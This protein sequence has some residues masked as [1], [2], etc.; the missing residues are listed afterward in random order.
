MNSLLID[1]VVRQTT[2]LIATLATATGNR[3]SL[4]HVANEVFANLSRELKAQG[5]GNKVIADMFGMAL[6]T[7]HDRV[8]RLSE[9]HSQQGASLWDAVL[10]HIQREG[11]VLRADVLRRFD[12]DGDAMVRGVLREL[13]DAGLVS[14]TGQDAATVYRATTP[15]EQGL[16]QPVSEQEVAARLVLVAVYRHG[17]VKPE[18]LAQVLPLSGESLAAVLERLTASGELSVEHNDGAVLYRNDRLVIPHGDAQGWQAAVFDHYQ[19]VVSALTAKLR[20]GRASS[21]RD[22][23]TGGSTYHFDVWEGHPHRAEAFGLLAEQRVRASALREAI[24]AHN[25]DHERPA[26]ARGER[27]IAYMGQHVLAEEESDEA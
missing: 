15:E 27:V 4:A 16:A 1:A 18:K 20:A 25:R 12:R 2:V 14:R 9:S 5:V 23:T 7:Y 3:A 6:R 17:P 21:A 26:D 19:A 22:E 8:A 24:E 11:P 10:G 13:V